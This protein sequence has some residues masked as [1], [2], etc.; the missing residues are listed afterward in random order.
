MPEILT[1]IVTGASAIKAAIDT[2]KLV[3]N[4]V[5]SLDKAEI[6]FQMAELYNLLSDVK[7]ESAQKDEKILA[8]TK[9]LELKEN[10]IWVQPF[11][12]QRKADKFDGPFCQKCF[13]EKLSQIRI[14]THQNDI[15]LICNVC[16]TKYS[17][18]FNRF[19]VNE[20]AIEEFV[21]GGPDAWMGN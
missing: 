11:Y 9:K 12:F 15:Y 18:N 20:A 4:S 13:D 17:N 2:V 16:K 5:D 19:P 7:I 8:L 10:M 6:K 14:S 1:T 3:K 21:N